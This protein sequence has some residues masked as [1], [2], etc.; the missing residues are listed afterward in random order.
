MAR[1]LAER[2]T[3]EIGDEVCV[4][5]IGMRVNRFWK[6]H[7]WWPVASAMRRMLAEPKLPTR[8]SSASSRGSATRR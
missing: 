2:V 7:R 6:V 8:A 1:I 5:L 3:A 4:F